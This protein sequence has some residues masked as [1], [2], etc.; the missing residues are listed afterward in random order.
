MFFSFFFASLQQPDNFRNLGLLAAKLAL[1][2][3]DPALHNLAPLALTGHL[4]SDWPQRCAEW[5]KSMGYLEA[6]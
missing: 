1:P 5:L 6:K 3:I 4:I 2:S